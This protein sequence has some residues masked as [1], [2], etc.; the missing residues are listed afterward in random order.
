MEQVKNRNQRKGN[1]EKHHGGGYGAELREGGAMEEMTSM[2]PWGQAMETEPM[3]MDTLVE[4][5]RLRARVTLQVQWAKV[6]P[7]A[8]ATEAEAGT[9]E[10]RGEAGVTEDKSGARE[11]VEPNRTRRDEAK[12]EEWNPVM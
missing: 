9:P 3:E 1:G 8:C 4:P 11:N 10:D 12:S 5:K 7:M 2:T 6:E